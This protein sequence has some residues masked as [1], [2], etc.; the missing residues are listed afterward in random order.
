MYIMPACVGGAPCI[1][2]AC[3][4]PHLSQSLASAT[5]LRIV[6]ERVPA[7]A[8]ACVGGAPC[9]LPVTWLAS[10]LV[11]YRAKRRYSAASVHNKGFF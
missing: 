10:G 9:V 2:L 6:G 5:D 4:R 3:Q 8:P 1:G 11:Y 7:G